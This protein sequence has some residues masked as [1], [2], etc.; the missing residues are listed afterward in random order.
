MSTWVF[1]EPVDVLALRGNR[2]FGDTGSVGEVVMP[3]PPSV[4]AGAIRSALLAHDKHD[5]DAFADGEAPHDSLGTPCDPGPFRIRH[6]GLAVRDAQSVVCP[7]FALPADLVATETDDETEPRTPLGGL[8]LTAQGH[9]QALDKQLPAEGY[10][11]SSDELW[12]QD[13]RV[14][15][16]LDAQRRAADDGKLFS[17]RVIAPLQTLDRRVG[18]CVEL[19]GLKR[20]LP[21]RM[22]LRFGGDGHQAV[23]YSEVSVPVTGAGLA[24]EEAARQGRCRLV[25]T[26]PGLFEHGW[27]L[28]GM[29]ESGELALPGLTAR[30][31]CASLG[32]MQTVS[33]YDLARKQPK[34]A[35]RAVPTGAVYW[36][37]QLETDA[38][39]LASLLADGLWSNDTDLALARRQR[40][41]E[42]FNRFV[43]G[44][45]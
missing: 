14:G 26:S 9:E 37:D 40:R 10:C 43:L 30:V 41:T 5:F 27:R 16:G 32:R 17:S 20:P 1:I 25:L 39:T 19:D 42:G 44:T 21:P 12:Q 34:P 24:A 22:M 7:L 15:I 29:N 36:I 13:I 31:V 45:Y 2:L 35:E 6:F 33:G 28:P 4:A 18:F 23:L 8:L 3:P 38:K 11:V